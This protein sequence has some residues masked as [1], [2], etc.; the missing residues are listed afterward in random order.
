MA[1]YIEGGK[2]DR[3]GVNEFYQYGPGNDKGIYL[4]DGEQWVKGS[5]GFPKITRA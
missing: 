2:G 5:T 1:V 4:L 3:A